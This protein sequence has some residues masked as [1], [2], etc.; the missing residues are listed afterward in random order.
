MNNFLITG[1]CSGIGL[2]TCK[3][4]LKDKSN[5]VFLVKNKTLPPEE[6]I[7]SDQ[8][9]IV[10][11]ELKSFGD[12]ESLALSI[13]SIDNLKGIVL[14]HGINRPASIEKTDEKDFSDIIGTNLASIYGFFSKLKIEDKVLKSIVIVSS[15]CGR[16]GGPTTAHYAISKSGLDTLALNQARRMGKF[17][18]RVNSI[19]PGYILTRMLP[20][21]I[22]KNTENS[23][24]LG[25]AGE[26]SE[27]SSVIEFL[28]SD[29]SSYISGQCINVDGGLRL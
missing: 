21:G 4:L 10:N 16:V 27:I 23:I 29:K 17:G 24:I 6:L 7:N 11:S 12:G 15:F 5:R 8:I 14:C 26:A 18:I 3:S 28:L 2:S 20:N 19:A 9:E 22:D 1:G 13:N 25:R